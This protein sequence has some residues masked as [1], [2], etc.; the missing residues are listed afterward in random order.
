MDTFYLG[1]DFDYN[2]TQFNF[3]TNNV[4]LINEGSLYNIQSIDNNFSNINF[5]DY[6]NLLTD[7]PVQGLDSY[8]R[9]I[10]LITPSNSNLDSLIDFFP[11]RVI[12][13]ENF[14][15]SNLEFDEGVFE[16]LS[17]PDSKL[18]YPEPFVASPS[19]VHE[20]MCW[21][22]IMHFQ[23]WLWFF[24]ISLIMFFFITFVNTVRWC[25]VRNKPERGT[26][27]A[28]RSKCADL[29]TAWVPV[30]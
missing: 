5:L 17:T 6:R 18:F 27:G 21:L 25:N 2:N 30:S 7:L 13:F 28:S 19:F 4:V 11:E 20:D 14:E 29:T 23:H 12:H 8:I 22:H 3:F 10:K 1:G 26:R 24:L 16:A 9:D 15:L